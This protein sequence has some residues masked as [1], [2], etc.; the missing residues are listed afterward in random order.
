M[1]SVRSEALVELTRGT[2]IEE[3]LPRGAHVTQRL[4]PRLAIVLAGE[5]ELRALERNPHVSHVFRSEIANDDLARLDE[6]ERL[7]AAGWNQRR[8]PKHRRGEGLSWDAAGF[9]PP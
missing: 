6:R 7:F 4:P 8:E 9:D 2:T 3:A 5:D 1:A